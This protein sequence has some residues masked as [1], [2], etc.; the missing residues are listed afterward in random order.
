MNGSENS[1]A[2][3]PQKLHS[4]YNSYESIDEAAHYSFEEETMQNGNNSDEL[5]TFSTSEDSSVPIEANSDAD[6]AD[7]TSNDLNASLIGT[8]KRILSQTRSKRKNASGNSSKRRKVEAGLAPVCDKKNGKFH[9]NECKYT[10]NNGS[11]FRRHNKIRHIGENP[12]TCEQCEKAFATKYNLIRHIN[13]IHE[14]K[15]LKF[16]CV[17]CRLRFKSQDILELHRC[18][19]KRYECDWCGHSTMNRSNILDHFRIHTGEKPF[20]CVHCSKRFNQKT[21]LNRHV[22]LLH[23]RISR[24]KKTIDV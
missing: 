8:A 16:Q 10:T 3:E 22:N 7:S 20:K 23:M 4:S 14:V 9:C 24:T 18:N 2:K 1:I 15:N 19:R 11:H 6:L 13:L 21:H 12:F 5:G 17:N